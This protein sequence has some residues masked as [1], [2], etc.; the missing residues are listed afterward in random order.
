[1]QERKLS[2]EEIR[3]FLERA[4]AKK[5]GRSFNEVLAHWREVMGWDGYATDIARARAMYYED[6]EYWAR[7]PAPSQSTPAAPPIEIAAPPTRVELAAPPQRVEIAAPV[8]RAELTAGGPHVEPAAAPARVGPKAEAPRADVAAAPPPRTEA[9]PPA[10]RQPPPP[11]P[12]AEQPVTP[13]RTEEPVALKQAQQPPAAVSHA[14]TGAAQDIGSR[15]V[16]G[17]PYP[18]SYDAVTPLA[19]PVSPKLLIVGGTLALA[20]AVLFWVLR[21]R[22]R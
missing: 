9:A 21:G 17:D 22:R 18:D 10:P 5:L 6:P 11:S 15:W 13:Q 14:S 8:A 1:M 19:L 12:R 4:R 16:R 3:E 7:P 20:L 2:D